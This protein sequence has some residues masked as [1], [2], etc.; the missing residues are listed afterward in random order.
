MKRP[1]RPATLRLL[2]LLALIP[3]G[4]K[5]LAA[6]IFTLDC[7]RGG[8]TFQMILDAAE[9]MRI[10]VYMDPGEHC[11]AILRE[12]PSDGSHAEV[13]VRESARV[14]CIRAR[15]AMVVCKGEPG[16]TCTYQIVSVAGFTPPGVWLTLFAFL[17]LL[18]ILL[19]WR[20][21][22]PFFRRP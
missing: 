17:M 20:T 8:G 22:G 4:T 9:R 15:R 3:A 12:L 6:Q 10:C 13:S 7:D 21:F 18:V 19:F 5:Q 14:A 16:G 11:E 1:T 2:L